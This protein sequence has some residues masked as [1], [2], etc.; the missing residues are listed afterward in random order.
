LIR[1]RALSTLGLTGIDVQVDDVRERAH[2]SRL[3]LRTFTRTWVG[4][5][6]V[7]LLVGGLMLF[8]VFDEHLTP[9]AAS[10]PAFTL[11][12]A[13]Y[14]WRRQAALVVLLIG[15]IGMV[16]TTVAGVSLHKPFSPMILMFLVLYSVGLYEERRG[17]LI[18]LFAMLALTFAAIAI[19]QHNGESYGGTDYGFIAVLI[20][21][22]WLVGRL[23]RSRVHEA[24]VLERRA[25]QAERER[26]VAV[27]EERARIARELHDVIAHS[28]SVM[29]VQAGAGEQIA[30][31]APER[32]G[33]PLRQI[34][35]TGRQALAEMGRL[36]GILRGGEELGLEPQPGVGDLDALLAQTRK[37]GLPVELT[38]EGAPRP[39]PPGL[40]LSAYRIVQ[41]ALTNTRKHAGDARAQVCLRYFADALE[42][43]VLDDGTASGNGLGGGHGLVGMRERVAVFGGS[44]ATGPRPEGCFAVN[45]TLPLGTESG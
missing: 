35:A 10:V 17:A 1:R 13:A 4:D 9:Y 44:L 43:E 39:L 15:G 36:L 2:Y 11:Y 19:A 20:A 24:T 3:V 18:G 41:E 33:E 22:P 28:L 6:V 37:A 30:K 29:V 21:A 45:A 42:I 12:A 7:A 8:E 23:I 25:E 31:R 32:V 38:V 5:L 27:E 40:D 14:V 26:L 16:V 34:Q